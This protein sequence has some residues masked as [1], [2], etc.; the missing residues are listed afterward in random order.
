MGQLGP[1]KKKH[2]GK[3]QAVPYDKPLHVAHVV[4]GS[5]GSVLLAGPMFSESIVATGA[6]YADKFAS[7]KRK[8]A[9]YFIKDKVGR[10]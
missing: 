2:M 5:S 3:T 4:R 7:R 8:Y 6:L 10:S 1:S 9:E